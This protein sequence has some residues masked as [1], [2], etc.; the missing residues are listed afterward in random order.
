MPDAP[1]TQRPA[2]QPALI[3]TNTMP[4]GIA[5]AIP[6][7]AHTLDGKHGL[8]GITIVRELPSHRIARRFL[9][10]RTEDNAPLMLYR[11]GPWTTLANPADFVD[12]TFELRHLRAENICCIK[13]AAVA[14][15]RGCWLVGGYPGHTGGLTTLQDAINAREGGRLGRH[16][17]RIVIEQVLSASAAAHRVGIIH[18]TITLDDLLITPKGRI[19]V[20][21]YGLENC[22]QAGT[23]NRT[24]RNNIARE[25]RSIARLAYHL[26]TGSPSWADGVELSPKAARRRLLR[27][28]PSRH[29]RVWLELALLSDETDPLR[30]SPSKADTGFPDAEQALLALRT[31]VGRTRQPQ[32]TMLQT[33]WKRRAAILRRRV[34]RSTLRTAERSTGR[35]R[36]VLSSR[37]RR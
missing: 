14:V 15:D 24:I 5:G 25:V 35:I 3:E 8:L 30:R 27:T 31:I 36:R 11:V 23:P 32:G 21:L 33:D 9:A 28:I 29:W 7:A 4:G 26:I 13:D 22:L 1:S 20:E 18:G 12:R 6:A 16:E 10:R 34:V 37:T 2:I 19:V 17:A